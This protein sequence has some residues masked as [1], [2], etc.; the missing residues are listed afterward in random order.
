MAAEQCEASAKLDFGEVT[1][2]TVLPVTYARY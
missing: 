1:P 2:D